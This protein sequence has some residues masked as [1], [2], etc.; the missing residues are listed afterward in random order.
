MILQCFFFPLSA[1]ISTW[2]GKTDGSRPHQDALVLID[3]YPTSDSLWKFTI[4]WSFFYLPSCSPQ[5]LL[6]SF[7]FD[8][9]G[10]L[11][12]CEGSMVA[13]T[14]LCMSWEVVSCP[15]NATGLSS[16]F[17]AQR[18]PHS[19]WIP[20]DTQGSSMEIRNDS[21][22]RLMHRYKEYWLCH[23]R[24]PTTLWFGAIPSWHLFKNTSRFMYKLSI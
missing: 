3:S 17:R 11:G 1:I 9:W 16:L 4:L 21:E 2:L 10:L 5:F 19:N 24:I 13:F 7:S 22:S 8:L 12:C 14:E 20:R 15:T 23:H 6:V 18:L